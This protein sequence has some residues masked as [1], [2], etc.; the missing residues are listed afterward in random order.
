MSKNKSNEKVN[1]QSAAEFFS[2]HQQIA[3]FDNPGK[4]LFTSIR[5]LIENSLDA[6]ESIHALPV[7]QVKIIEKTESEHN[8]HFGIQ[9][10]KSRKNEK[11]KQQSAAS[12]GDGRDDGDDDF[13]MDLSQQSS[14]T[15]DL[16]Q[17]EDDTALLTGKKSKAS[18]E[19]KEKEK[20]RMYYTITVIDNGCGIPA[21]SIGDMLGR[22][23]SGSK[24]GIRQTRGKFGL[25]AKMALIWAKKSSGQPIYIRTAHAE[26]TDDTPSAISTV[27]L[28]ID[29]YKNEPKIISRKVEPN[30]D[31]WRGT[32]ISLTMTGQ[33]SIYKSKVMQYVQQLAVITPYSDITVEY[34]CTRDEKKHFQVKFDRRSEQMPQKPTMMLPHPRSLNNITLA[35]LLKNT[36]A[37]SL[38]KCLQ[39]DMCGISTS[40]AK[41]IV[42][43]LNL[44]NK[45][46]EDLK[47]NDISALMQSLRDDN[48]IKPPSSSCLS[49]A[50]EYNLRL[51]I[52]KELNPTLVATFTDKQSGSHEGHP[53]IVE[54]AISVGGDRFKE[55]I[56]IFRF[57]N[58]I[59]LLFEGGA[60]VVT[61]VATKKIN[62]SLYHMDPKK[63]CIGVFVSIVSTKIPFKGTSKE[64]IGDDVLEIQKSV[65]KAILGC[66]QQLRVNLAK[67]IAEKE[68]KERRKNLVKYIPDITR[69]LFAVLSKGIQKSNALTMSSSSVL[70]VKRDRVISLYE[71]NQLNEALIVSKLEAGVEKFDA[72]SAL[73]AQINA[74]GT[75][76]EQKDKVFIAPVAYPNE[77]FDDDDAGPAPKHAE[78]RARSDPS[79][80]KEGEEAAAAAA[81]TVTVIDL[82]DSSELSTPLKRGGS[83]TSSS[84]NFNDDRWLGITGGKGILVYVPYFN[85]AKSK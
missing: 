28:D 60:D 56:N 5:E 78:K 36:S 3:G 9:D 82:L 15:M 81:V 66:C 24:H 13:N 19:D 27:V 20:E 52:V 77:I 41:N 74:S 69:S 68:E 73:L 83:V 34:E 44:D 47:P 80:E 63:D 7:I 2:E 10:K 26:A 61:Q 85:K 62:W 57:A 37:R 30:P 50:G 53:F 1:Q 75:N 33:W 23:L 18:K 65:R 32:E 21:N 58:R 40:V 71:E 38:A 70:R 42:T 8:S 17:R 6:A 48:G 84:I 79:E 11:N 12:A 49:P 72:E 14:Q 35:N 29:I 45:D 43:S 22:V 39:T 51:G 67:N 4:S 59:P 25:G 16:S 46:I 55:G 64:Y 76:G 54:A 31:N